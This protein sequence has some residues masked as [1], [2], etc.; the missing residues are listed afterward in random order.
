MIYFLYYAIYIGVVGV[1]ASIFGLFYILNFSKLIYKHTETI[2]FI[3]ITLFCMPFSLFIYSYLYIKDQIKYK[4]EE[5]QRL[6]R[7]LLK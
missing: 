2:S 5:K 6:I 1:L 4:R 7:D 3:L